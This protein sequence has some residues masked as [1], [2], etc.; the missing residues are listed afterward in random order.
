MEKKMTMQKNAQDL[1]LSKL[2]REKTRVCIYLV[3]GVRLE[4]YIKAFDT[5]V[6]YL[7]EHVT[8][9][10]YKQSICSVIPAPANF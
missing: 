6:I 7:A 3:S 8:Q 10:V 1:F 4:G 9:A 5:Y 2:C